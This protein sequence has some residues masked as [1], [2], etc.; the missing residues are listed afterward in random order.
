MPTVRRASSWSGAI[1]L[2]CVVVLALCC[3]AGERSPDPTAIPPDRS[4]PTMG[5]KTPTPHRVFMHAAATAPANDLR[6]WLDRE[7]LSPTPR[8]VR[9]PLFVRR[10]AGGY[11]LRGARIGNAP[12]ALEV[13]V[14]DSALGIGLGD[15][16]AEHCGREREVCALVVD[17]YWRGLRD[18]ERVLAVVSVRGPIDLAARDAATTVEIEVPVPQGAEHRPALDRATTI[19]PGRNVSLRVYDLAAAPDEVVAFY[20]ARLRGAVREESGAAV[21]FSSDGGRVTVEP[22]DTGTRITLLVRH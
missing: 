15:R 11:S 2:P 6:E 19:N 17:G 10:D 7:A 18:G 3:R 14:D 16:A 5:D 20:A 8:L 13:V 9:L 22:L 21:T 4:E 1:V 12:D